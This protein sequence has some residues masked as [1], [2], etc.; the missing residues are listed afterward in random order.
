MNT[1]ERSSKVWFFPHYVFESVPVEAVQQSLRRI[2]THWGLPRFLRVDNGQ[3]WGSRSDLPSQLDVVV[4]GAGGGGNPQSSLSSDGE[5]TSR[6]R[7]Q[8]DESLG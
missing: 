7:S 5:C 4:T 8:H 2:F 1:A 3:P 6:A